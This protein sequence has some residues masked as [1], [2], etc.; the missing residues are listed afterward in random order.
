MVRA[1]LERLYDH[2]M[3]RVVILEKLEQIA[4]GICGRVSFFSRAH[5]RPSRGYLCRSRSATS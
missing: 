1:A 4:A 3:V 2:P 5:A